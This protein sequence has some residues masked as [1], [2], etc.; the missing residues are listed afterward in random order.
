[1]Q[2]ELVQLGNHAAVVNARKIDF[3]RLR[4]VV[5]HR[6]YARFHFIAGHRRDSEYAACLGDT[7]RQQAQAQALFDHGH[8][9]IPYVIH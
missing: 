1:M 7:E 6:A 8:G 2:V 9:V 4:H 3:F 5:Q